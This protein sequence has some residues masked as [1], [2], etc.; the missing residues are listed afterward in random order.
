V[1]SRRPPQ[2]GRS[3]YPRPERTT[4][5]KPIKIKRGMRRGD[6]E[7]GFAVEIFYPGLTLNAGDI[8]IGAFGR[9]DRAHIRPDMSSPCIRIATTRS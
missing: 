8:G 9:V 1:Q 7:R 4:T 2:G 3:G 6:L 5:V